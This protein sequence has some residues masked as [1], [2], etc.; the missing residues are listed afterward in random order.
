MV[1]SEDEREKFTKAMA[2]W[3]PKFVQAQADYIEA[4]QR[5]WAPSA[6]AAEKRAAV[7]THAAF[8][9]LMAEVPGLPLGWHTA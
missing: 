5:A 8:V 3:T 9:N 7:D 6:T 2:E 4:G 1:A